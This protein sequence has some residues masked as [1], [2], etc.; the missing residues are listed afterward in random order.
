MIDSELV[1]PV[2]CISY[3]GDVLDRPRSTE[4]MMARRI[5]LRGA[6]YGV[7]DRAAAVLA[8]C[9]RG[10]IRTVVY[11]QSKWIIR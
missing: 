5:L 9:K 2:R 3:I 8:D 11:L 4:L 7:T 1:N 10:D 6:A